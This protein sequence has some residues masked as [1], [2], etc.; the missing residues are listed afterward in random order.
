M[1]LPTINEP[2][3]FVVKSGQLSLG[4]RTVPDGVVHHGFFDGKQWISE[5][6]ETE[7]IGRTKMYHTEQ[8]QGWCYK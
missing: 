6:L 4:Y 8:I 1:F 2:I 5:R 3:L 7:E